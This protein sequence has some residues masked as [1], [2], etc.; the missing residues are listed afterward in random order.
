MEWVAEGVLWGRLIGSIN[1]NE[2]VIA[3]GGICW[4]KRLL[5]R[6]GIGI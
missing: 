4:R 6:G 2:R 5:L 3:E 1:M